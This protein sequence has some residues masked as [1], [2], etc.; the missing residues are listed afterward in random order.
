M[1]ILLAFGCVTP[2]YNGIRDMTAAHPK[3]AED[4]V[5]GS[6]Y[7]DGGNESEVF[8]RDLFRYVNQ[9]EYELERPR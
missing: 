6:H 1:I 3:G 7:R 2:K 5:N 4:A 8:I 9:L